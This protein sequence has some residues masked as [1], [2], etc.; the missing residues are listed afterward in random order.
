VSSDLIQFWYYLEI[1]LDHWD[2]EFCIQD[3]PHCRPGHKSRPLEPLTDWLLI[4]VTMT[5]LLGFD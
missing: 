4:G 3:C 5:H 2:W 1:V